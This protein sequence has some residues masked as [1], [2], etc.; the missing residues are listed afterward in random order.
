MKRIWIFISVIALVAFAL[1]CSQQIEPT[2]QFSKSKVAFAATSSV[3]SVS[4]SAKDSLTSVVSLTWNDPKFTAG[5][6]N[7]SIFTV[8]VSPTGTNFANFGSK[9]FSGVLTGSL[10][11]KELNGMA[12][13]LGGTIGQTITLDV[14]VV[15]SLANNT[16]QISSNVLQ[17]A[18]SPYGDLSLTSSP[19][20]IITS[21]ANSLNVGATFTWNTA[22]NGYSGVKTYQFQYAAH[23]TSFANPTTSSV[24]GYSQSFT[25]NVL[26]NIA[27]GYGIAV[28]TTGYVDFRIKASNE[29]GDVLYSNVVTDT[30]GTFAP[31]NS[32]GI[33]GDATPGGWNND[34]D[35]FRPDAVNSPTSW[36]VNVYLTGGLSAKFRADDAWTTNWGDT[37][38]PSGTGL[39]NGSN[40]PVGAS[41]YYQVN[42]NS[43][44]GAYSFTLL[45]TPVYSKVSA[46]GDATPGGWSTDTEL[47]QSTTNNQVWTGTVALTAGGSVKFRAND[48]W[49]TNWG[50]GTASPTGLSGWGVLNG[51]NI[52]ITTSGKY[53]LYINAATGE[54]L[55]GS[56]DN[57]AGAGTPYAQIGI[58]GDGTPG[59]W[60][61]DTFLIQ[62]PANP[63]KWSGKVTLTAA[64]AKFRADAAWTVNWGNTTF[65]N[66][67]GTVNGAN[68][69]VT[70]G[71][72]QITFNSA[73]GEY[74][75]T[76]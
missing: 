41:G 4:A 70:A 29:S 76:Y 42:F 45:T 53:F 13:K 73:T 18:V 51:G 63:Y 56:V 35:L 23:G 71:N 37:H 74:T 39:E 31:Y 11:G 54:Y 7:Q 72:P 34:V 43:A 22:F 25:Q 19:T 30:I 62:D 6:I 58:I 46:I 65:P 50:P 10:L 32:I 8:W 59:G 52:A 64:S 57:N 1:S 21:A 75:F 55:I 9:V 47:T 3:T 28:G 2:A 69:P 24:T 5:G 68:I 26:N 66:G 61:T 44:T 14:K 40:I 17:I 27:L 16:E 36:T 20:K 38:W 49:T 12:L 15:A 33:I 48:A 60:N 67:I